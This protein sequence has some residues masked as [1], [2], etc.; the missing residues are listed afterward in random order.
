MFQ[1]PVEDSCPTDTDQQVVNPTSDRVE[2]FQSPVEDSCPTDGVKREQG[3]LLD[4]M[5]QSPVEDSC[6]T[7]QKDKTTACQTAES[8]SPL[9]RIHAP[10]TSERRS[11]C[12][13]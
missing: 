8:F 1:S 12:Q 7:D 10:L 6:P 11:G 9:S 4:V 3:L 5:F 13:S 2:E